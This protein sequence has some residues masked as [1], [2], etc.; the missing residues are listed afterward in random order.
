MKL[1]P[2]DEC[3]RKRSETRDLVQPV[4]R[5][6]NR[7]PGVRVTRNA[8]LGPVVPYARRHEEGI[9]PILAGLGVGSA[10][11]VGVV[12]VPVLAPPPYLATSLGR[13]F[14]LEVK[15]PASDGKRAGELRPDQRRWLQA[16]R[17]FGGFAAVVTSI[18]EARAAVERCRHGA[19]E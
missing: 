4:I 7:M 9:R 5:A 19:S 14:V 3:P 15:L 12:D 16:V 2:R 1:M 8:N 6:L 18:D 11:V 17:R 13:T 10:D